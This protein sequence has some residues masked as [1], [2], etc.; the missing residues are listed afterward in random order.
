MDF[1]SILFDVQNLH[2][3]EAEKVITLDKN[4]LHYFTLS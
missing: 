3:P 1:N 4:N 2:P